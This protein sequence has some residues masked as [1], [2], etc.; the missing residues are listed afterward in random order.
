MKAA[1]L[2]SGYLRT[3]RNNIPRIKS[4]IIEKLD[5]VDIYSYY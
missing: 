3:F 5:H 4:T 1:L 2:I